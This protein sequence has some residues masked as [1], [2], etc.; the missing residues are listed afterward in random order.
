L[1][2]GIV[3]L[4]AK[5]VCTEVALHM[6]SVGNSARRRSS[7]ATCTASTPAGALTVALMRP[8]SSALIENC[9]SEEPAAI[10]SSSLIFAAQAGVSQFSPRGCSS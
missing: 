2:H 1:H 6:I 10:S 9:A 4:P 5:T 7:A 3:N 8:F